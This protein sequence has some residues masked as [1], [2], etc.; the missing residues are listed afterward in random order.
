MSRI[1]KKPM[2]V[3]SNVTATV[4]GQN[5]KMKG[6]KGELSFSVPEVLKVEKTAEGVEVDARSRTPSRHAPSGACRAPRSPT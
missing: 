6:P 2:S 5:V 3:P 4:A 1:G